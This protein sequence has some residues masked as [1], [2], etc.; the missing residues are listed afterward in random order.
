M[1]KTLIA[2]FSIFVLFAPALTSAQSCA[3]PPGHTGA[4]YSIANKIITYYVPHNAQGCASSMEG[5][6]ATSCP[7]AEPLGGAYRRVPVCLDDV[8]LKGAKYVT[9]SSAQSNYGKYYNLGTITYKSALDDKMHTVENVIGYVH[10]TGCAFNGTCSAAMRARYGFSSAPRPDKID[11]CTTVCPLCDDAQAGAYATGR[12]VSLARS[13]AGAPDPVE[14]YGGDGAYGSPFSYGQPQQGM[15]VSAGQGARASG[16]AP[17]IG[18]GNTPANPG[19]QSDVPGVNSSPTPGP[20]VATLVIQS[21]K[22]RRGNAILVAWSTLGMKTD[23]V[24]KLFLK[25]PGQ[26]ETEVAEGNGGARPLGIPISAQAGTG[27]IILTCMPIAGGKIEKR[28]SF[29]IE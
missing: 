19:T 23:A 24:C 25:L 17:G 4:T 3:R 9:L 7:Y 18:G 14:V 16:V 2:T 10:D 22:V 6:V 8:R 28:A 26:A 21:E 27:E 15:Q 5:C 12:N 1:R 11:V 20:G 13:R 29:T